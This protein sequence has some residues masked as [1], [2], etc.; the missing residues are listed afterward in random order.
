MSFIAVT[1]GYNQF[2]IFNTNTSTQTLIDNIKNVCLSQIVSTLAVRDTN[3]QKEID[4][5]TTEEENIK[6]LIKSTE[7][8]LKVEED[9]ANEAKRIQEEQEKKEAAAANK[10]KKKGKAPPPKK[11]KKVENE[12]ENKVIA[13]IKD[14]LARFQT[15]LQNLSTNKGILMDKRKKLSEILPIFKK[16]Q[17]NKM[18]IKIDLV[19]S[20]GD[21][22]NIFTKADLNSKEYLVEKTVYELN[23]IN[24]E[25]PENPTL[26]P[27]KF[28]GYCM[29]PIEEDSRF[30]DFEEGN[31]KNKK[32]APKKKK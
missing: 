12:T 26:E 30:E 3:L 2:S 19:D 24:E 4:S 7:Q 11:T 31:D 13:G 25:N 5:S 29:R 14:N 8:E 32:Q 6:K 20:K 17:K 18:N 10:A 27:L 16:K 1:Y 21:K 15:N 28:D 22:V 23:W 9:K